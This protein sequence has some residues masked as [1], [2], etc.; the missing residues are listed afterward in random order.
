MPKKELNYLYLSLAVLGGVMILAAVGSGLMAIFAPGAQMMMPDQIDVY[1]VL[2]TA[3]SILGIGFGLSLLVTGLR[4]GFGRSSEKFY[5]R[6]RWWI[7]VLLLVFALGAGAYLAVVDKWVRLQALTH[8]ALITLPA[9]L[10]LT[11]TALIVGSDS[12]SNRRRLVL[13]LN[14]GA[15]STML[16]F[17]LEMI[18]LLFSSLGVGVLAAIVPGGVAELERLQEQI[19]VWLNSPMP[20]VTEEQLISLLGS[21]IVLGVLALTLAVVTP[22]VEEIVKTLIIVPLTRRERPGA[23]RAFLWGAGCGLGFAI[24]EG[25]LNSINSLGAPGQWASGIALRIPATAMHAFVSGLIGVGWSAFWR[26][27]RR[28]L[29]P[30]SYLI[31]M[32]FHA[33]WN[34]STIGIVASSTL[35]MGNDGSFT[36]EIVLGST[37]ALASGGVLLIL[38]LLAP[39]LLLGLPWWLRRRKEIVA[40]QGD[41]SS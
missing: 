35:V 4:G 14:T 37:L 5:P 40:S 21:P 36:P 10:F 6:Y 12:A 8:V 7:P 41:R 20:T 39:T 19:T 29:L 16:A 28:W 13:S 17:P 15:F 26:N 30:A 32:L 38:I 11:F 24:V 31:S 23:R 2:F 9:L 34:F 18:G 33:L 3:I 27:R 22:F 1:M 25:V